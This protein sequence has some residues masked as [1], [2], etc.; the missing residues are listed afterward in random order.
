MTMRA[1]PLARMA[2]VAA[3]RPD[4]EPVTIAHKP[5]FDIAFP[6]LVLADPFAAIYHTCRNACKPPKL[7][8]AELI[9][10]QATLHAVPQGPLRT[11]RLSGSGFSSSCGARNGPHRSLAGLSASCRQ[12]EIATIERRGTPWRKSR[13]SSRRPPRGYLPISPTRKPSTATRKAPGKRRCGR[14]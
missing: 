14:R 9:F 4:A 1:P 6:R 8:C 5:S 2:A 10:R 13:T 3:P 12:H 11:S 7:R